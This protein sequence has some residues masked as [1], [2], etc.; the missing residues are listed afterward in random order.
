MTIG[1]RPMV[2]VALLPAALPAQD[3]TPFLVSPAAEGVVLR[4]LW[5]EG[6]RPLGYHVE[7]REPG[8]AWTRL[9]AQPV[10][11]VRDRA[12]AR[13][14][15]GAGFERY[16]AL[17][18]PETA[19]DELRDPDTYRSLLLLVA[20]VE[21]AVARILGLRYDDT[22]AARDRLFE[23]RLIALTGA[24]EREAG[25]GGP[26]R[27]GSYREAR[28]PDSLRVAQSVD[29][30]TLKWS[31]DVGF[32]AYHVFRR[33]GRGDWARANDAPVVV[34]AADGP[35][36]VEAPWFFRDSAVVA[37]D[38][39]GYAIVGIDPFGRPSRRSAEARLAVRDLRPPAPPLQ[40]TTRAMGDTV[41]VSWIPSPDPSVASYRVWRAPRR[42]GPFEPAGPALPASATEWR[43]AGR[44]AGRLWWYRVTAQ[45]RDGNE[46]DPSFLAMVEVRDLTPPPTPTDLRGAA[47]TAEITLTWSAVPSAGIRGYRVYRASTAGG[48]FGLLTGAPV[49]SAAFSDAIRRGADQ[50]FHYRVTA[51]DS[52]FNESAPSAVVAVSPPDG[53]APSAP[54]I[55]W[56]RPGEDCLVVRW[57][58]NP[59]PD[60]AAYRVRYRPLGDSAWRDVAPATPASATL[61][62]IAG[63]EPRR[64]YEVTVTAVDDAGNASPPSRRAT[65]EPVHRRPPAALAVRRARFDPTAGGVVVEWTA[66]GA[67]VEWVRVVRR[68]RETGSVETVGQVSP[69]DG[70]LVDP[71][72]E[73]GRRYEYALRPAD[74]FGNSAE[75]RDWKRVQVPEAGR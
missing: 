15:L 38:T 14:R 62:T 23:Y 70:R 54:R 67:G 55:E 64:L 25:Q 31:A 44:P 65:G 19:L 27:A 20:D 7:R 16:E 71:R 2:L 60:V 12:A 50:A 10:A 68:D 4:W 43:D 63:L 36:A 74:R 66:P 8:G 51:V 56:V 59:E 17:L 40:V 30:V 13:R 46:S 34:F 24:G 9:T 35:V 48:E 52:A 28:A 57:F 61:D 18:F 6:P 73:P 26:V 49:T 75:P 37:G 72:V 42:E 53:R 41:G 5:P 1:L 33:R 39:L 58:A 29:G 21:P 32:S 11:R 47:D 69:G 45:D 3:Q 22:A